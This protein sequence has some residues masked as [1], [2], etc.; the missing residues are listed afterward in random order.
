MG[1]LEH[2]RWAEVNE[3]EIT[4]LETGEILETI[5]AD[6]F[7]VSDMG[8]ISFYKYDGYASHVGDNRTRARAIFAVTQVSPSTLTVKKETPTP[9]VVPFTAPAT[10]EPFGNY[11][12]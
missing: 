3:Y 11:K 2:E 9:V 1:S 10:K 5:S 12:G 4:H 7:T 8:V 6:G